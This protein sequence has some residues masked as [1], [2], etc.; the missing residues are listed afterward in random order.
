[1][2]ETLSQLIP[3]IIITTTIVK[4]QINWHNSSISQNNASESSINHVK[5]YKQIINGIR[6]SPD[7]LLNNL[8][9]VLSVLYVEQLHTEAAI[10]FCRKIVIL[11]IRSCNNNDLFILYYC[12]L[13]YY[14][15]IV[16]VYLTFECKLVIK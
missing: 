16:L 1:M 6:I 13:L 11:E 14:S 10:V 7:N 4:Y 2:L 3:K 12:L 15:N 8:L 5:S 9:T